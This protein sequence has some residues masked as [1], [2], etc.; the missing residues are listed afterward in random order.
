M[1][2]AK[3][4]KISLILKISESTVISHRK[5]MLKKLNAKNTAALVNFAVENGL[6]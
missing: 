6:N 5:N 2:S 3:C 1:S 4:K